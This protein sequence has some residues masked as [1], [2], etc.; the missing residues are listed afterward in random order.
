[1]NIKD[2]P[3]CRLPLLNRWSTDNHFWGL[4]LV[5]GHLAID[6]GL[7]TCCDGNGVFVDPL[8]PRDAK[9]CGLSRR[10]NLLSRLIEQWQVIEKKPIHALPRADALSQ[11]C[12]SHLD[13][14]LRADRGRIVTR[15]DND[16]SKDLGLP[17]SLAALLGWH[18]EVATLVTRIGAETV[19][20]QLWSDIMRRFPKTRTVVM[21]DGVSDMWN[22]A[23][24]EA[25][26]AIIA[27]AS[28]RRLPVWIFECVADSSP[29][30]VEPSS[31]RGFKN[32]VKGRIAQTKAKPAISWLSDQGLSR[33]SE[34]C[35]VGGLRSQSQVHS[36][37]D[38]V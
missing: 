11:S 16:K 38:Q 23:R 18:F 35:V 13:A 20:V 6:R 19:P 2:S 4:S 26:E 14:L 31:S 8:S 36:I 22:P 24:V 27:F 33:L 9:L 25:L 3:S 17:W 10:W 12:T 37:P 7:F 28:E 29:R 32:A 5:G 21:I 34:L 30:N 15:Q 1:M